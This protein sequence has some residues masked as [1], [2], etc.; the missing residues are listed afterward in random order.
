MPLGDVGLVA[1]AVDTILGWFTDEAGYLEMQKQRALNVKKEACRKALLDNRFD[2]LVR[3]TGELQR[4]STK[5]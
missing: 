5:A 2:D 3:L 4:L 1:K